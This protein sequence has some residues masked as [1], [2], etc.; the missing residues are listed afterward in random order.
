MRESTIKDEI[1]KYL[2][3]HENEESLTS[4]N[5]AEKLKLDHFTVFTLLKQMR[6]D[7]LLRAG[8]Y[9]F[10]PDEYGF[11]VT[12]YPDA[13]HFYKTT[14]YKKKAFWRDVQ[15]MPKKY[16][17]VGVLITSIGFNV[18]DL[19]QYFSKQEQETQK[20]ES[21]TKPPQQDTSQIDSFP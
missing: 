15:D 16:W 6:N 21:L 5:I 1:L 4:Y 20:K 10:N 14:S 2:I 18:K 8:N 12:L 7:K 11:L 13:K 19:I 3:E 9:S 17:F